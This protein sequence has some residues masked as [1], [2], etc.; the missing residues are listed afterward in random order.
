MEI[1]ILVV[2]DEI[3]FLE[4]TV[5]RLKKKQLDAMGVSSGEDALVKIKEKY[6]DVILLDIKMPGGMDGI[7]AL[8]EIKRERPL[9]EVI[10]LTGHGSVESSVEGMRLGAFDYILKPAK[11]EDLCEKIAQAYMKKS[12]QDN[13][14]RKANIQ[15]LLRFPG[16]VFDQD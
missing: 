6:F 2:D 16:R 1:K 14:I 7:E 3:D 10:L 4:T 8:R 13:K 15:K 12:D 5:K 11:F 9:S